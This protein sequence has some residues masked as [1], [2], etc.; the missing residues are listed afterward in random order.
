VP[1]LRPAYRRN[2][3]H[4]LLRAIFQFQT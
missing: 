1:I 2:Q 4:R 3:I